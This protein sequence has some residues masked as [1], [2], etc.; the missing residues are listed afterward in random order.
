M[1]KGGKYMGTVDGPARA[2]SLSW[3][4]AL[5]IAVK[6]SDDDGMSLIAKSI[7][8]RQTNRPSRTFVILAL[9]PI[10]ISDP[11]PKKS[12]SAVTTSRIDS[13]LVAVTCQIL[14][15]RIGSAVDGTQGVRLNGP[16]S[17]QAQLFTF[18][19]VIGIG[20]TRC[21]ISDG[22]SVLSLMGAKTLTDGASEAIRYYC[23]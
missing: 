13:P 10:F 9:L 6:G 17:K 4:F 1:A 18:V 19:M 21:G 22:E 20:Y 8:T 16:A 11:L 5:P 2:A 15:G 23:V 7:V 3:E 12:A 14:M